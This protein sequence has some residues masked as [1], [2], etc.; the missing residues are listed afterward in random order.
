LLFAV[1]VAFVVVVGGG[2]D[3]RRNGSSQ[4]KT[5]RAIMSHGMF[6][7][8]KLHLLVVLQRR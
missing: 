4:K 7:C 2:G 1:A 8:R 3:I 5:V 6:R